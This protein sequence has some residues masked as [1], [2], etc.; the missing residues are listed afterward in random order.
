MVETVP[1][2][3]APSMSVGLIVIAT[4]RYKRLLPQLVESAQIHVSGL[5]RIFALVDDDQSESLGP[6]VTALHWD[7][8]P[9]PLPTLLRYKAIAHHSH[10]MTGID[11]LVY[12]D[13]DM[14]F[15]ARFTLPSLDGLFAVQHPGCVDQPRDQLPFERDPLSKAF[16]PFGS[17][18]RYVCG[19]VQGGETQE[20]LAACSEMARWIDDERASGRVPIWHDESIWNRWCIEHPPELVLP[21][22]YCWPEHRPG[23][24]PVLIA[25]DKTHDYWRAESRRSAGVALLRAY[26]QKVRVVLR[27]II[28]GRAE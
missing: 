15:V 16:V 27:G 10:A 6:L 24:D 2:N 1:E 7:H 11:C 21:A 8:S 9:W 13:V 20:Y 28:S 19:G 12:V 3:Q 17:G 4:G 5:T 22:N 18:E 14:R 23:G 25:L 26:R